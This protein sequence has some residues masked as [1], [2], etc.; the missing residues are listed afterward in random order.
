[1][2]GKQAVALL[3]RIPKPE[4]ILS[5]IMMDE[6][7]GYELYDT[8]SR[9]TAYA[10]IPFIFLTARI[11]EHEKIKGLSRGAIDYITKPFD[12]TQ[13]TMKIAS[14]VK[15]HR[16]ITE[17]N[18]PDRKAIAKEIK[19][20]IRENMLKNFEKNCAVY[21][22][23]D[24]ERE[25]VSQIMQGRIHKEICHSLGITYNTIKNHIK[26]I[27]GKCSVQ[28]KAELINCLKAHP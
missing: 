19:K 24:R 11:S 21:N 10:A 28:T 3:A 8:L 18:T 12:M 7:D 26:R 1:V 6:M 17:A 23:T 5:D 16:K 25:I 9:Q 14:I 27:Y 15:N 20:K 4:L 13:L 2:N 22:L